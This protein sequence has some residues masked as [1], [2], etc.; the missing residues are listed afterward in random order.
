MRLALAGLLA[1]LPAA[2][3][4][5][6]APPQRRLELRA[7]LLAHEPGGREESLG[8]NG[9]ILFPSPLPIP[10]AA[11]PFWAAVLRPR[12]H[13]GGTAN[14]AGKTSSLHLGL[15]WTGF[16]ARDVLRPGD[17]LRLDVFGGGALNDGI[18]GRTRA[19]RNALGGN[20]LFR[21]GA[22]IGWQMDR[23][24]SVGLFFDHQSN[25]GTA[26][27]NQGLNAVGLR[28]GHAF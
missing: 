22:E 21:V 4:A 10:A 2:A 15:T 14:T 17:A 9:E 13:L 23:N 20:L 28:L 27:F 11:S 1:L 16:L 3:L 19:D 26:R 7:G 6:E 24:W 25:G 8:L 5:Q 12:P 18:H